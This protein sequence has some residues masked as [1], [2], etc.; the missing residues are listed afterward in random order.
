MSE[1]LY[2]SERFVVQFK[3]A[4]RVDGRGKCECEEEPAFG[5]HEERGWSRRPMMGIQV[6]GAG[7][8]IFCD[9]SLNLTTTDISVIINP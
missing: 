7:L 2:E 6:S 1:L 8:Q 3:T 4:M 5:A 9:I